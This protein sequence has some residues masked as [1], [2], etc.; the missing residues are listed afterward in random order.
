V[1]VGQGFLHDAVGH[2]LGAAAC[3]RRRTVLGVLDRLAGLAG[4]L[5][6]VLHLT[7]SHRVPG[8]VVG[9]QQVEQ[10]AQVGDGPPARVGDRG[11]GRVELVGRGGQVAGRLGLDHHRRHVVGHDVVEFAGDAGAFGGTGVLRDA[12]PP[13]GVGHSGGPPPRPDAP[14]EHQHQVDQH[15]PAH[16]LARAEPVEP[17]RQR[18][19]G[20][21]EPDHRGAAVPFETSARRDQRDRQGGA[22]ERVVGADLVDE[23]AGRHHG[24]AG[25]RPRAADRERQR[26]QQH[27]HDGQGVERAGRQ[28]ADLGAVALKRRQQR[29]DDEQHRPRRIP[30]RDV[31]PPPPVR[32]APK[33]DHWASLASWSAGSMPAARC[34]RPGTRLPRRRAMIRNT[35]VTMMPASTE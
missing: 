25:D 30:D 14:G 28:V 20:H 3:L 35:V 19:V 22:G 6:E 15:E 31:E 33:V 4:L 29:S 26:L 23:E 1:S 18:D 5:H 27:G 2:E 34:R 13:L 9:I 16:A 8:A 7:L 24:E 10:V 32:D 17:D 12:A 21:R 11:Q